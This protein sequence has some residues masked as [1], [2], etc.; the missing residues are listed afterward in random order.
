MRAILLASA[1]RTSIGG[2]RASM[3]A[4][5]EP[6]GSAIAGGP[7]SKTL[8]APMISRRRS[9]RSPIFEVAPS[10][11]LPPVECCKRREPDPG[12]KV[13]TAPEGLGRWGQRRQGHRGHRP[14]PGNGHQPTRVSFSLA[15]W[16]ISRSRRAICSSSRSE[17]LDQHLEDRSGE[18]RDRLVPGP[19]QPA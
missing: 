6:A 7:A 1:T 18:L 11:C 10:F 9:V 15:R 14:D 17:R 3:R 5:H 13:P 16:A 8:L 12:G 4:I 2:L 19:R